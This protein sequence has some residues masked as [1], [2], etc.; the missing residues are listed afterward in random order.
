MSLAA[1]LGIPL[2]VTFHG[3]DLKVGAEAQALTCRLMSASTESAYL[4]YYVKRVKSSASR[5]SWSDR[6]LM[7]GCPPEKV[8]TNYLG[9]D[10][11]VL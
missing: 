6:L 9:V 4:A 7:L 8:H 3:W 1:R 5:R 10:S 2:V 11:S